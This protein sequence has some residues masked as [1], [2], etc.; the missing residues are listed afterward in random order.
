MFVPAPSAFT[1]KTVV[2]PCEASTSLL[3]TAGQCTCVVV[4]KVTDNRAESV[5][6]VTLWPKRPVSAGEQ[7]IA[8][9]RV[10]HDWRRTRGWE[11]GRS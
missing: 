9:V 2:L 10:R 1:T 6:I 5:D 7:L 8:P 4:G 3:D 11:V